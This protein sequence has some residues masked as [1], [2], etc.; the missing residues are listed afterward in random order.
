MAHKKRTN[1]EKIGLSAVL[2]RGSVS[3]ILF[4]YVAASLKCGMG[5][6]EAIEDGLQHFGL[7]ES[8]INPETIERELRRMTVDYM[9]EGV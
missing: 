2:R 1:E 3:L 4:G 5:W 6:G 7:T 8:D 9:R